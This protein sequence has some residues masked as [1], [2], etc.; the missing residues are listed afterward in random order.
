MIKAYYLGFEIAEMISYIG[1]QLVVFR[2]EGERYAT[3]GLM[4]EIVLEEK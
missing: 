3:A 2:M 4:S 1:E